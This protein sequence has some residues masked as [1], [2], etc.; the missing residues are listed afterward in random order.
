MSTDELEAFKAVGFKLNPNVCDFFFFDLHTSCDFRGKF[1]FYMCKRSS[2][3]QL[4]GKIRRE[5]SVLK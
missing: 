1:L 4:H 3:W 5:S 2:R